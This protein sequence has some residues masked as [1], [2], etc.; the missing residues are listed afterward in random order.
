MLDLDLLRQSGRFSVRAGSPRLALVHYGFK[1]TQMEA[2][3]KRQASFSPRY[4]ALGLL[5]VARAARLAFERGLIPHEPE[6]KYFDEDDYDDDEAL[7]QGI[8]EWLRPAPARFLLV[9][10]YSMAFDRTTE[11]LARVDPAEYCIVVGGAHPTVAPEVGFAHLVVRGEGGDAIRHILAHL[12]EP[13]FGEGPDA[14]GICY[15]SGGRVQMGKTVFDR[16]L[17]NTPSPAFAYDLIPNGAKVSIRERW[18]KAVGESQQLYICTQSCLA[19]CTFCSTYPIH[20]RFVSRPI[21]LVAE[22]LAEIVRARGHDA[23]QFHDDDLLQH[24]QFDELLDLLRSL[25]AQWTCNARSVLITAALAERMA[26]SG[27]RKVFLGVESLDQRTL[28]YYRKGTTVE[29]NQGAVRALDEAGIGVVSGYIIGAPHDTVE[30]LLEDVDRVLALPIYFLAL[31]ILTPDIGTVEFLRAK[32]RF[33]ILGQLG[34]EAMNR[35]IRPRPDLFGSAAPFG[36]PTVCDRITKEELNELY[37]L[38]SAEF[39]ARSSSMERIVRYTPPARLEEAKSWCKLHRARAH[40]L[41]ET[42]SSSCEL[43]ARRELVRGFVMDRQRSWTLRFLADRGLR[44]SPAERLRLVQAHYSASAHL[45][46][47]HTSEEIL[48]FIR[49]ILTIP[50]GRPGCVVEA[51]C[52]KGSSAAKFSIAASLA[53]RRLVVCDSFQGLPAFDEKHGMSIENRQIVFNEG[54]FAGSLAEV[55]GNIERFGALHACGF[56]EGWFD[57]SLRSWSEP[58]AAIYL[59]VDLAAS[60]R[61]C[62]KYLYPWLV[63]GGVL[64]SQ[65][66]HIPLVLEVFEDEAF[67]R[68]EL[69]SAPPRVDGIW[70]RKLIKMR[71]PEYP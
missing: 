68:T 3:E 32:K 31:A 10:L 71:K 1:L 65:D 15:Q 11:F 35:N 14:R 33:P 61:A 37:A 18:W 5:N 25:G 34:D 42:L 23:I 7:T 57:E 64:Y 27:C 16:S 51:G 67:W 70:K 28:D 44:I 54:D 13:G 63:P 4:P 20:G 8:D 38:I 6:F 49:E 56:V 50:A 2:A 55:R 60:T 53:G 45:S 66:G 19:R 59:D 69:D 21:H 22:D 43:A 47:P 39:F 41:A 48:S 24:E 9:G 30:S 46:S 58:I 40:E 17:E 62:L 29:M 52:F 12:L 26:T 36:L